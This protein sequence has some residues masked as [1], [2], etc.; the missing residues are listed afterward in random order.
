[1]DIYAKKE[2]FVRTSLKSLLFDIDKNILDVYYKYQDGEEI[3]TI[4]LCNCS[5]YTE[6]AKI[7][8][9]TDSVKIN[10]TG[11]SLLAI[12]NDV[13]KRLLVSERM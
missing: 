5:Y 11:D 12:V 2:Y 3:V 4:M 8:V 6:N 10:V 7:N 1:M 9:T 13:T